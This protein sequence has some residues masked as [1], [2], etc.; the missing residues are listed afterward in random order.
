MFVPGRHHISSVARIAGSGRTATEQACKMSDQILSF[1][2]PLGKIQ[3]TRDALHSRSAV[4]RSKYCDFIITLRLQ[5]NTYR[6][7]EAKLKEFGPEHRISAPTI[8]RNLAAAGVVDEAEQATRIDEFGGNLDFD[9]VAELR[10]QIY[11]QKTRISY[12]L[13]QERARRLAS[14]KSPFHDPRIR[15]EMAALTSM[16]RTLREMTT[17]PDM[18]PDPKKFGAVKLPKDAEDLIIAALMKKHVPTG[19]TA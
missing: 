14:P 2:D 9:P 19:T 8:W 13:G 7:I 16:M 18:T 17:S 1:P 11:I 15:D 6:E 12:L 10:K 5:G 3:R 4:R